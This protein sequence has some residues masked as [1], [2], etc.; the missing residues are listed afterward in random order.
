MNR[1][2]VV[3]SVLRMRLF[4]CV[5]TWMLYKFGCRCVF[6]VFKFLCVVE[7]V[8]S[9]AFWLVFSLMWIVEKLVCMR[10]RCCCLCLV[11]G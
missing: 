8:M 7:M 3:F 10:C 9:S 6:G 1:V 5:H 11:L 4:A 2:H